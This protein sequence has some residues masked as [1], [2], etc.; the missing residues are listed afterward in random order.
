MLVLFCKDRTQNFIHAR[1]ALCQ[2]SY[3]SIPNP[4][5]LLQETQSRSSMQA[6]IETERQTASNTGQKS[7]SGGCQRYAEAY[8]EHLPTHTALHWVR[9]VRWVLRLLRRKSLQGHTP[10]RGFLHVHSLSVCAFIPVPP[11]LPT[12][13][14]CPSAFLSFLDAYF[15]VF[16]STKTFL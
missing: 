2:L 8:K 5:P 11:C 16:I 7:R 9:K 14:L 1:Q 10:L 3:I 4:Y 6:Q 15:P 13:F 12:D